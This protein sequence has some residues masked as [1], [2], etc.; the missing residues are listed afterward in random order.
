MVAVGGGSAGED[1]EL[2]M[3]QVV[4]QRFD[5]TSVSLSRASGRRYSTTTTTATDDDDDERILAELVVRR[6]LLAHGAAMREMQTAKKRGDATDVEDDLFV[7]DPVMCG[8]EF[9]TPCAAKEA[10]VNNSAADVF[11]KQ[12]GAVCV[13]RHWVCQCHT[14]ATSIRSTYAFAR[15]KA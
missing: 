10:L 7:D 13:S 8:F 11:A 12:G 9:K 15:L 1:F 2:E 14:R 6:L 3:A 4:L 5:A